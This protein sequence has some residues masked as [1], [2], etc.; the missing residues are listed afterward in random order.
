MLEKFKKN[1]LSNE[2]MKSVKGGM[3][4]AC[5][6]GNGVNYGCSGNNADQ[7]ACSQTFC[8]GTGSVCY[9]S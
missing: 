9:P 6:C 7:I 4:Y 8:S 1:A 3:E 5:T 2:Q